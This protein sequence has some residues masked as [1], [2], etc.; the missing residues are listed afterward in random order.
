MIRIKEGQE[1]E[2]VISPS[3]E[4]EEIEVAAGGYVRVR[5]DGPRKL[6]L[7][8]RLTGERAK[9]AIFG[10]F[11]GTGD[12]V[13]DLEICV[14]QDAPNSTCDIRFR[15]ALKDRA[16]SRFDG[17]IRM[18]ANAKEAHARLSYRNLLLSKES[19]ALPTPRLE[20]LTKEVASASHEAA[21]GTINAEQLFYLQSRG[22][23][24]DEAKDLIVKGFLLC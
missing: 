5:L 13:Q 4:T 21:V 15:S 24:S 16:Y 19:R 14:V 17:L 2:L 22:L 6:R 11:A 1:V 7:Q 8:A 18:T 23:S 3:Q 20:V 12:D 9:I 10:S